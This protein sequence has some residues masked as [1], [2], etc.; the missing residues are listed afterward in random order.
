[1]SSGGV[2]PAEHLRGVHIFDRIEDIGLDLRVLRREGRDQRLDLGAF[3]VLRALR[4][5]TGA[6]QKA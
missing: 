4:R 5:R 6:G 2:P 3:G 1:M